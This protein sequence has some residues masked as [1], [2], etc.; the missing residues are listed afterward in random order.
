MKTTCPI[1]EQASVNPWHGRARHGKEALA[2]YTRVK[3]SQMVLGA[4]A[5]RAHE[6]ARAAAR[7]YDRSQGGAPHTVRA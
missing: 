5:H 7:F 1:C 4:G 3:A 2:V 6:H